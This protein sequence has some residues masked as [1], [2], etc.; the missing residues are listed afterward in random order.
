MA[1][2]PARADV[3]HLK[4]RGY[5]ATPRESRMPPGFAFCGPH[6]LVWPYSCGRPLCWNVGPYLW[7][8]PLSYYPTRTAGRP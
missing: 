4:E 1:A 7:V 5:G 8:R 6:I 2:K 3:A